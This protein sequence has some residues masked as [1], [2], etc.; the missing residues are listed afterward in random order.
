[1]V[2]F[3]HEHEDEFVDADDVIE[4][5]ELPFPRPGDARETEPVAAAA[6]DR[7]EEQLRGGAAS[8]T[9]V[10]PAV[11]STLP[12]QNEPLPIAPAA[13]APSHSNSEQVIWE[14][15]ARL[16]AGM[17]ANPT[18]GASSVKDAVAL[19]DEL[20]QE[21]RTYSRMS[22]DFERLHEH[23]ERLREEHTARFHQPASPQASP[24]GHSA[25]DAPA[26]PT[27]ID[28]ECTGPMPH[29]T[30]GSPQRPA[31]LPQLP[32][33]ESNVPMRMRTFPPTA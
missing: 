27:P 28:D 10:D 1:M 9:A 11:P 2:A 33:A 8:F 21:M 22:G 4:L 14:L 13:P 23:R 18:K 31:P 30:F 7:V 19:F 29:P 26:T 16:T 12:T 5:P 6:P 3:A 24:E 17:L 15:A 32:T 20:L 25:L